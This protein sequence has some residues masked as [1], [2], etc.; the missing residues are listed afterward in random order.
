MTSCF[1]YRGN[2]F[3]P[4]LENEDPTSH[5]SQ[6]VIKLLLFKI[7]IKYL[8]CIDEVVRC[9]ESDPNVKIWE[10]WNYNT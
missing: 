10:C 5:Y 2:R 1:H 9:Q 4:W 7:I 8:E 3:D 6:K